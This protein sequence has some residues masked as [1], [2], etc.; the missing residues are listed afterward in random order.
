MHLDPYSS[1]LVMIKK[2]FIKLQF[3]CHL[4]LEDEHCSE[5]KKC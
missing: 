2:Y 5:D 3:G 1:H 4:I